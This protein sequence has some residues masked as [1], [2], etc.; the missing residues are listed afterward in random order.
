MDTNFKFA[1]FGTPDVARRTLD[2]LFTNGYIPTVIITSPDTEKGRGLHLTETPVSLWAREHSIPCLKPEKI[3]EEFIEEFKQYNVDL[4]LVV[5][6]GKLLPQALIDTPRLKTINIHY[7]LLPTYRGASPV[8]EAL[9]NGDTVTGVSIQQM[10]LKLDSGPLLAKIEVP[11]EQDEGKETLR[12]KLIDIGT[13]ELIKILPDIREGKINPVEQDESQATHCSKIK[14]ED[15][16]IN[17]L[18]DAKE[19]YNKYRAFEGWP[20]VYFFTVRHEKT[21]RVKITQARYENNEFI[22]EK[23]IPEGKKEMLYTDFLRG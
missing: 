12:N 3:T 17:P 23:V 7:S 8:E 1:F 4:S 16:E 6:Y 21:I 11:I 19:N 2:I 18:G 9:L 5:A 13:H 14:K 22:I 10:Q 15:G 20:G